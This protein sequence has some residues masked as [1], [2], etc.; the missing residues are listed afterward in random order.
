MI[1]GDE[2]GR[3]WEGRP[4]HECE[5]RFDDYEVKDVD[6]KLLFDRA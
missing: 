2:T 5:K 3:W 1:I 4:H 6:Y